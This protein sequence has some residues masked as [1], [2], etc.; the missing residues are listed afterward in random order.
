MLAPSGTTQIDFGIPN[1]I[2]TVGAVPERVVLPKFYLMFTK[3]T[4]DIV[5]IIRGPK[6]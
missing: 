2:F 6:T 1:F 4:L 3:R 5:N